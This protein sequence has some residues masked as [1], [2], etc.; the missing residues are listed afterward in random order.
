MKRR[1]LTFV[2][3]LVALTVALVLLDV[4]VM[5]MSFGDRSTRLITTQLGLQQESRKA[6]VRLMRELQEGMEVLRPAPGS[7][8]PYAIFTDKLGR[9]RWL[10]LKPSRASRSRT[11]ELWMYT[12]DTETAVQPE[13]LLAG[14][15]RLGFTS[16]SEGALQVNLVLEEGGQSYP[17]LTTIR[18]RNF[19]ASEEVF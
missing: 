10:Y 11:F 14:I 13:A 7:T 8:L 15:Q 18:L 3:A 2:E 19:A 6:L 9:V 16:G 12:R 5:L 1:A 17:M 4:L